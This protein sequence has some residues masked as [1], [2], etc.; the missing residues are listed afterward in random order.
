MRNFIISMVATLCVN[1]AVAQNELEPTFRTSVDV[2]CTSAQIFGDTMLKYGETPIGRGHSV[3][4]IGGVTM[5]TNT[6]LFMNL[7]TGSWTLAE[8]FADNAFCVIAMGQNWEVYA[9]ENLI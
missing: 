4:N 9:P 8:K 3:R 5:V 2:A 6:V 1:S 7:K